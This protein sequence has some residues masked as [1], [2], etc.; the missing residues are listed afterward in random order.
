MTVAWLTSGFPA[1]VKHMSRAFLGRS[2]VLANRDGIVNLGRM[3]YLFRTTNRNVAPATMRKSRSSA[4][5]IPL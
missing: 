3:F 2:W 5:L 4:R 1:Y